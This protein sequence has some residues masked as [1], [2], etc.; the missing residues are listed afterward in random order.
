MKLLQCCPSVPSRTPCLAVLVWL[1][2]FSRQTC[3]CCWCPRPCRSPEVRP[4]LSLSVQRQ[5]TCV[6]QLS[7][8]NSCIRKL[9]GVEENNGTI[10]LPCLVDSNMVNSTVCGSKVGGL[11]FASLI[12][13]STPSRVSTSLVSLNMASNVSWNEYIYIMRM[14]S[15][16]Q[17]NNLL[18][19]GRNFPHTFKTGYFS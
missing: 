14:E 13:T 12:R 3:C 6:F 9:N 1:K 18:A 19:L 8:R 4:G 10:S 16:Q 5:F 2:A 17:K 7:L 15:K 11:S